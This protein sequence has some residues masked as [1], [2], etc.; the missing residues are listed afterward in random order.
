MIPLELLAEARLAAGQTLTLHRRENR[1]ALHLDRT[2]I[3]STETSALEEAW[4]ALGIQIILQKKQPRVLLDG[5]LLGYA[6]KHL[7]SGLPPKA[8][9][10]VCEPE[11]V[12]LRWHRAHL[13]DVHGELID[14]PR[15]RVISKS[16]LDHLLRAPAYY[17]A[18]LINLDRSCSAGP[19]SSSHCLRR[20]DSSWHIVQQ[21]LR[22]GGRIVFWSETPEPA[23]ERRLRRLGFATDRHE[24]SPR[25]GGRGRREF[26]TIAALPY[27]ST[28]H[29]PVSFP[30]P[31]GK[32]DS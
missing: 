24:I 32:G 3:L 17:D 23:R 30:Q 20:S 16:L 8:R 31:G 21:G 13:R 12:L 6:L 2:A 7:A 14:D 27:I 25:P 4:A 9:I 28:A 22:N 10:S 1:F 19:N 26:V 18:V 15:I 5:L 29:G 11:Q